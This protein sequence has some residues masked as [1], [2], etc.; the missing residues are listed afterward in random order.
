MRIFM[1][2]IKSIFHYKFNLFFIYFNFFIFL[3]NLLIW[4]VKTLERKGWQ[5]GG[6]LKESLLETDRHT[7]LVVNEPDGTDINDGHSLL[8]LLD[9]VEGNSFLLHVVSFWHKGTIW[10]GSNLEL[11]GRWVWL[12]TWAHNWLVESFTEN[13]DIE[14][15]TEP[16]LGVLGDSIDDDFIKLLQ[17]VMKVHCFSIIRVKAEVERISSASS[18]FVSERTKAIWGT[19]EWELKVEFF[20]VATVQV[21]GLTAVLIL[22]EF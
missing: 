22:T 13:R 16:F 5:L 18:A 21:D 3:V 11:E 20:V 9:T 19:H 4:E 14:L 12:L 8:S 1:I 7:E 10:L 2:L 6:L 17:L 15:L